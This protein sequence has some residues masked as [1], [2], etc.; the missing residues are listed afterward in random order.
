MVQ[1]SSKGEFSRCNN[2]AVARLFASLIVVST[3]VINS[4]P[5]NNSIF[6]LKYIKF[7]ML[8]FEILK[9]IEITMSE[10][11]RGAT[12]MVRNANTRMRSNR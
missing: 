5:R 11:N 2:L 10:A 6:S 9:K 8:K 3:L 12:A 1:C 7:V 4:Y